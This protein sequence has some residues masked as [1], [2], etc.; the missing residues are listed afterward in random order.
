MR[1][2]DEKKFLLLLLEH[3][4][5]TLKIYLKK[6]PFNYAR[7]DVLV[8]SFMYIAIWIGLDIWHMKVHKN[9]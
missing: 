8:G 3:Y 7:T 1:D 9:I 6:R 4:L 2:K 5:G